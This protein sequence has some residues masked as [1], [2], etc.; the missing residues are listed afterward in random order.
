[1]HSGVLKRTKRET[2][3]NPVRSR[4]CKQE[5]TPFTHWLKSREG[6]EGD[7]CKP[8]DLPDCRYVPLRV[9]GLVARKAPLSILHGA[10]IL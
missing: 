1:M 7:E 5:P 2:G 3:E 8:G 4:H 6:G 10:I 9:K